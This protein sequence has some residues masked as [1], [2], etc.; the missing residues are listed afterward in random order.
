MIKHLAD[1]IQ[2]ETAQ[3][4]EGAR[5]APP[6]L[7]TNDFG[8]IEVQGRMT[9]SVCSC[10]GKQQAVRYMITDMLPPFPTHRKKRIRKK[11][12]KRWVEETRHLRMLSAMVSMMG[13]PKYK[14]VECGRVE[15]IYGSL[16]RNLITVEPLP[17]GAMDGLLVPN[18]LHFDGDGQPE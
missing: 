2:A 8:A 6:W 14:C 16:G 12:A 7:K 1:R 11:L 3:I 13:H 9:D 15:S 10:G 18:K 4:L 17:E 5:R